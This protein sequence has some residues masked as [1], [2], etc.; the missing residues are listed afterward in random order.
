MPSE[1]VCTNEQK[2]GAQRRRMEKNESSKER[3]GKKRGHKRSEAG[4]IDRYR[5]KEEKIFYVCIKKITL[6]AGKMGC[7]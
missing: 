1:Y 6:K 3:N 2:K 7:F 5:G 4:K